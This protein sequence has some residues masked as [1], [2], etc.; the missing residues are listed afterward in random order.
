MSTYIY[1]TIG[2]P[3]ADVYPQDFYLDK[4]VIL[5]TAGT[6][7]TVTLKHLAASVMTGLTI[8]GVACTDRTVTGASTLI[9]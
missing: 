2:I 6:V 5:T 4:S 7:I 1:E 8:N 3:G 9:S